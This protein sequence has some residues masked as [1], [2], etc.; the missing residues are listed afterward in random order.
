MRNKLEFHKILEVVK[1]TITLNILW[2]ERT[3]WGYKIGDKIVSNIEWRNNK[4]KY[5]NSFS[6]WRW[7]KK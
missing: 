6:K 4:E 3:E 2:G 1:P 5:T 7:S